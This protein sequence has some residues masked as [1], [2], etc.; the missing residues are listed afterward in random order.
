MNRPLLQT[1]RQLR[2]LTARNFMSGT[3]QRLSQTRIRDV[4]QLAAAGVAAV[5]VG[6]YLTMSLVENKR[7]IALDALQE[8]NEEPRSIPSTLSLNARVDTSP[9]LEKPLDPERRE[10]T[11]ADDTKAPPEESKVKEEDETPDAEA[12]GSGGAFNPVTGEINWDCP[13]LGG[14]A[15]GPCGPEFREAF[16]CFVYS[17]DEPKGI[18]CVEKFK[19]MQD[20]FRRY[21]EEYAEEIADDDEPI[22]DGEESQLSAPADDHITG[23]PSET[24]AGAHS[25]EEAVQS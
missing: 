3:P 6:T 25:Q 23:A 15:H 4:F 14:M 11:K 8:S 21:P 22:E 18:N 1:Q 9:D 10:S 19:T 7:K 16:S 2:R 20:C 24:T 5:T 17:E 13:C 12:E